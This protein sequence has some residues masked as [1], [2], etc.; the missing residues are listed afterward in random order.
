M[1]TVYEAESD[2]TR[3]RA[4]LKLVSGELATVPKFRERFLREARLAATVKHR[5]V[6]A[7]LGSGE[8][9]GQLYLALELVRGGSLADRVKRGALRWREV[10]TLG[11]QIARALAAIH[12]AGIVHRDL[13]PANVLLA[14]DGTPKLTDFGLARG[15]GLIALT[16]TG[17]LMGTVEYMA[18]EQ[19]EGG[20]AVDSRA[21]LYALGCTLYCLIVGRPPFPG[22]GP[23]VIVQHLKTRPEPLRAQV[24]ET[25]ADLEQIVLTLLAKEPGERG[26]SATEVA[27]AL[28][29][30]ARSKPG[31]RGA[32]RLAAALGAVALLAG[33]VAAG[34]LALRSRPAP[35]A[36]PVVAGGSRHAVP[37]PPPSPAP[38]PY[39]PLATDSFQVAKPAWFVDLEKS[40]GPV[41]VKLPPGVFYGKEPGVYWNAKDR[42]ELVYVPGGPVDL[43]PRLESVG[44]DTVAELAAKERPRPRELQ[45]PPLTIGPF[46]L[47]RYEV[48]N[49]QFARYPGAQKVADGTTGAVVRDGSGG[50]ERSL[51]A[52]WKLPHGPG[53]GYDESW[54]VVQV[55]W[56]DAVAYVAW[57]G[58]RLPTEAEWEYGAAWDGKTNAMRRYPWGNDFPRD[59]SYAEVYRY[60]MDQHPKPHLVHVDA[61]G[62]GKSFFGAFNMIGNAKEWVDEPA[63][64]DSHVAKGGSFVNAEETLDRAHHG[65]ERGRS[66]DVGFRVA[67]TAP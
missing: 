50:A 66:N 1:G 25:P 38:G 40:G 35:A 17:D 13:K 59:D 61:H 34:A 3:A 5:N 39:V 31:A 2:A 14:E 44:G 51:D 60:S 27:M 57:A 6:V 56:E 67:L 45:R 65:Y 36:A 20:S 48:S 41:P 52:S 28:E 8:D 30:V 19:S 37:P 54:P 10:A 55:T 18:P 62:E 33:L 16:K 47:G 15:E 49:K 58:L 23:Q 46:F 32:R 7:C 64:N 4:A 29:R 11:G 9:Q 12:G 42:S 53:G 43:G 26:G 24:P 22:S 21:D 63:R